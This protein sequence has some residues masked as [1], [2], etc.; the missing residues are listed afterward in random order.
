[1]KSYLD[2]RKEDSME[3]SQKF[4]I[5]IGIIAMLFANY[6]MYNAMQTVI[7]INTEHTYC[8]E[9]TYKWEEEVYHK[10]N[11]RTELYVGFKSEKLTE[12]NINVSPET[13]FNL[14]E[15]DTTCFTLSNREAK[16]CEDPG[17]LFM[18]SSLIGIIAFII[19]LYFIVK[20]S[21]TK[22]VQFNKYLNKEK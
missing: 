13:Y 5:I 1:M 14:N 12:L 9:I 21:I 20:F 16:I 8:G 6:I 10:R 18:L 4:W 11:G 15:G 17:F 3:R 2:N 19:D 7:Y 22:V